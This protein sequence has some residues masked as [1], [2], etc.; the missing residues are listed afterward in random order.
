[1]HVWLLMSCL[2]WNLWQMMMRGDGS[3]VMDAG[4]SPVSINGIQANEVLLRMA[5][6]LGW[7]SGDH[8]VSRDAP[9]VP[10]PKLVQPE[11]E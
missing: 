4:P 8:K 11:Q 3:Y 7:S 9:P 10:F 1:M 6:D 2:K 5:S